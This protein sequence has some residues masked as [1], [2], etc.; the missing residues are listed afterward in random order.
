MHIELSKA[1][2]WKHIDKSLRWIFKGDDYFETTLAG[3]QLRASRDEEGRITLAF[4]GYKATGFDTID[5]ARKAASEFALQVMELLK[6]R[7]LAFPPLEP[8]M[9]IFLKLDD[10]CEP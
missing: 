10:D 4:M 2:K 5:E 8:Q 9:P 6:Q 3:E 1:G 7:I